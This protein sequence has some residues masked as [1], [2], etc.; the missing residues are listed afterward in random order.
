MILVIGVVI[1][2]VVMTDRWAPGGESAR[3]GQAEVQLNVASATPAGSASSAWF[4]AGGIETWADAALPVARLQ[5]TM[6]NPGATAAHGQIRWIREG[7]PPFELP[8]DLRPGEVLTESYD[9]TKA[10]TGGS[11]PD[12]AGASA[13]PPLARYSGVAAI[14]EFEGGGIVV[15][16]SL[17]KGAGGLPVSTAPC[18]ST[19]GD[20]AYALGGTTTVDATTWLSIL[21]PFRGDAVIDVRFFT[22]SGTTSPLAAQGLTIPSG[23]VR[24]IEVGGLV[25]RRRSVDAE[26]TARTG[27]IVVDRTTKYGSGS[28]TPGIVLA[29]AIARTAGRAYFSGGRVAEGQT[30]RYAVVNPGSLPATVAVHVIANPASATRATS[31]AA[32]DSAGLDGEVALF[33]LDI[34]AGARTELDLD[35]PR[36]PQDVEL[37]TA[38]FSDRPVVAARIS[39]AAAPAMLRG[40]AMTPGASGGALRWVTGAGGASSDIDEVISVMNVSAET[41][42]ADIATL[43]GKKLR[44]LSLAPGQAASVTIGSYVAGGAAPLI[45]TSDALV[46]VTRSLSI[47]S[48]RGSPSPADAPLG[49]VRAPGQGWSLSLAVISPE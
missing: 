24:V 28:A 49:P 9:P 6:A 18:A 45:V 17:L 12:V 19:A 10:G 23:G 22:D 15:D 42:K 30:E 38:F 43:A 25:R 39:T 4:C 7:A 21:N 20:Q 40:P 26:V 34:P 31:T 27:R 37:S 14:I 48:S 32:G 5:V 8:V 46:L 1:A 13:A 16:Q 2:V 29:P 44:T 36:V 47:V 11:A 35:D 41:A 33:Q 3:A